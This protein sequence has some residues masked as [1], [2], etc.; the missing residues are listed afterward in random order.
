[1][2]NTFKINQHIFNGITSSLYAFIWTIFDSISR[3]AGLHYHQFIERTF[4]FS[5][6]WV[7]LFFYIAF[8]KRV[9]K[10]LQLHFCLF[11]WGNDAQE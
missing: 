5:Y 8:G 9:S 4:Y 10:Y 1:M 7:N 11:T 3:N 2:T 6:K